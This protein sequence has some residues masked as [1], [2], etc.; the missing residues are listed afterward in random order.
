MLT[1][2]EDFARRPMSGYGSPLTSDSS[3]YISFFL[4][5]SKYVIASS[6][7]KSAKMPKKQLIFF[8]K[9]QEIGN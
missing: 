8:N 9:L 3:V 1:T 4:R 2:S 6:N 7:L 5:F